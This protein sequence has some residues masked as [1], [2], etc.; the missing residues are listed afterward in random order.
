MFRET[1]AVCVIPPLVPDM[2]N[3][4]GPAGV[5]LL[6]K[7]FNEDD[8]APL[9]EAGTKLADEFGGNPETLNATVP[10]KPL[11][12]V[13][14]TVTPAL[15]AAVMVCSVGVAAKEKSTTLRPMFATCV[16]P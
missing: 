6:V 11:S 5:E 3:V 7:I 16:K 4:D 15:P 14:D 13:V 1:V 10:A 8:P 9:I 12:A 2:V